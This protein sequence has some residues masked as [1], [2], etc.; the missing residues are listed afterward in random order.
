MDEATALQQCRKL[1]QG[2]GLRITACPA[3]TPVAETTTNA[4]VDADAKAEDS[5]TTPR[6][7]SLADFEAAAKGTGCSTDP[8]PPPAKPPPKPP[9]RRPD[10][11]LS[12]GVGRHMQGS[13]R[14]VPL[15]KTHARRP[16]GETA[17]VS[18]SEA[19]MDAALARQFRASEEQKLEAQ[20]LQRVRELEDVETHPML[21]RR[22]LEAWRKEAVVA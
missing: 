18:K 7:R 2:S 9:P 4:M 20:R 3:P 6:R 1:W 8:P 17:T 12:L 19:D 14:V 22:S 10:I 11:G 21:I 13:H 16:I 15:G 5:P